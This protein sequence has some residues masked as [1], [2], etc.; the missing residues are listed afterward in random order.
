[1]S[2]PTTRNEIIQLSNTIEN[3]MLQHIRSTHYVSAQIDNGTIVHRHLF[4]INLSN[5]NHGLRAIFHSAGTT[6]N[7]DGN[8]FCKFG[9]EFVSKLYSDEVVITA[10]IGD[11]MAAQL[12]GLAHWKL[13]AFQNKNPP[14][15]TIHR[16]VLFVPC[17]C[18]CLNL[19]IQDLM[20]NNEN[21]DITISRAQKLIKI[22][23][24]TEMINLFS[25]RAPEIPE[26]R[27]VYIF[28]VVKWIEKHSVKYNNLCKDNCLPPKIIHLIDND[29]LISDCLEGIPIDILHLLILF[30]PI[31]KLMINFE[32]DMTPLSSVF[33][34]L[35]GAIKEI[36]DAKKDFQIE[37][38][39]IAATQLQERI[40]QRF[41]TT[42][43]FNLILTSYIFTSKGRHYLR[44]L[45]AQTQ[46]S[47]TERLSDDDSEYYIK[48]DEK[49]FSTDDEGDSDCEEIIAGEIIEDV[50]RDFEIHPDPNSGINAE[51]VEIPD[52][53]PFELNGS[54]VYKSARN[55]IRYLATRLEFNKKEISKMLESFAHWVFKPTCTIEGF[56]TLLTSPDEYWRLQHLFKKYSHLPEIALRLLSLSAS[57][58]SCERLVSSNRY[59]LNSQSSHIKDDL[60]KAR[61]VIRSNAII[62]KEIKI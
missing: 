51:S 39:C 47:L 3:E 59:I 1:M 26:S 14:L 31:K 27:W 5:P 53:E 20:A 19:A 55:T 16:A 24:K 62:K 4:F 7:W 35:E 2:R 54:D 29:N 32:S 37:F 12:Y 46:P 18:H 8:D 25:A 23:R 60:L 22:F 50:Q 11:N 28:D 45:A 44:K 58:A 13:T 49:D 33:E 42:A 41:R 36:E 57:E 52:F 61:N 56:D 48:S 40:I 15:S 34:L 17:S 38:F 9:E 43:D 30:A 6:P 10:F 21:I